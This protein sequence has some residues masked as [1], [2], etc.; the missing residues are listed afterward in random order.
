MKRGVKIRQWSGVLG[1]YVPR[2]SLVHRLGAGWMF[3]TLL[4]ITATL[5]MV[6]SLLLS[7]AAVS[8]AIAV[9]LYA[10]L[11]WRR[12]LG[13]SLRLAL[14][15]V[16]LG[17]FA[18]WQRG[19]NA[20][21]EMLLDLLAT[22]LFATIITATTRADHMIDA[23][24]RASEPL[25]RFGFSPERFALTVA[26]MLRAIPALL[27]YAGE[28]RD[29]AR[30]RGIERSPRAFLVPLAVRSV[31]RAHATGEALTARGITSFESSSAQ[32]ESLTPP[33]PK[34]QARR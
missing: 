9:M 20:G 14:Y 13:T 11:G 25:R 22:M 24:A 34:P 5:V 19:L 28:V 27:G 12:T 4:V 6:S 10:A 26:L 16:P 7:V 17:L 3:L 8:I 1:L 18:W 15:L 2:E 23:I 32:D 33:L 29:A 31:T 30:A 21:A